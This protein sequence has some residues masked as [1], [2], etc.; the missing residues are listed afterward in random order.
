M[1]RFATSND[2]KIFALPGSARIN[3]PIETMTAEL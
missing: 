1:E 2:P 3:E